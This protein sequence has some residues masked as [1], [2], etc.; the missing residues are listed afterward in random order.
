MALNR[1]KEK[2]TKENLWLYILFLLEKRPL[3][4][5][6]ISTRIKTSFGFE[7]AM[8]TVYV[9]LYKMEL[10]GLVSSATEKRPPSNV[11]RRYYSPTELGMKALKEGK[12]ILR[13]TL[14][15]L[16][17]GDAPP[18]KRDRDAGQQ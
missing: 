1:L 14:E 18:S 3:Y 7:P 11:V 16:E 15:Q 17:P 12:D 6:E 5:Y 8:I 9:V 4:A 2:L 13:R 10:E